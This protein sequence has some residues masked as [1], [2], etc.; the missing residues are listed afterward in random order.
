[1][2]GLRITLN[3]LG[4][5]GWTSTPYLSPS[6][7][8]DTPSPCPGSGRM[9]PSLEEWGRTGM[10]WN[11]NSVQISNHHGYG[12]VKR[13]PLLGKP[14]LSKNRKGPHSFCPYLLGRTIKIF[15]LAGYHVRKC[16]TRGQRST[17]IT[18][19]LTSSSLGPSFPVMLKKSWIVQYPK[20]IVF[21][22]SHKAQAHWDF[23]LC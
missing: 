12:S 10:E 14:Y 11:N 21:Y 17:Q 15:T 23:I 4:S 7:S 19:P 8:S 1:M 22:R 16:R 18:L 9:R 3:L 6:S 2:R 13:R 20:S 5:R